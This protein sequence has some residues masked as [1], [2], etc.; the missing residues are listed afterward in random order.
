[1]VESYHAYIEAQAKAGNVERA[2]E[3]LLELETHHP[4]NPADLSPAQGLSLLV[5]ELAKDAETVDQ[6]YLV[7]CPALFN[8]ASM[9][10]LI[11]AIKLDRWHKEEKQ[12]TVPMLDVIVAA[13]SRMNDANRAFE[14]FE[15]YSKLGLT[16]RTE[17]Y[18]ALM[19]VCSSQRQVEVIMKLLQEMAK[20]GIMPN[21]DTYMQVRSRLHWTCLGMSV[22][23]RL[24]RDTSTMGILQESTMLW[25][26]SVER[27][28][29]QPSECWKEH[30][31]ALRS[32][33]MNRPDRQCVVRCWQLDTASS[34]HSVH[35]DAEGEGEEAPVEAFLVVDSP[36]EAV[37][38]LDK[39]ILD[40][41]KLRRKNGRILK[42]LKCI[43]MSGHGD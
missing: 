15:A 19:E 4:N 38:M 16:H 3:T 40:T 39:M 21:V 36:V 7:V 32:S 22:S 42:V 23:C 34:R 2:F 17:S 25:E 26:S 13:C 29:H 12:V 14:T 24:L 11:V 37:P 35:V 18:N 43:H 27:V 5:D 6:A 30:T 20:S 33:M 8:S 41:N 9:R 10:K 31:S 1:M 28:L